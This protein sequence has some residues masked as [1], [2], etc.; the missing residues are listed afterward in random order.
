ME[1][2]FPKEGIWNLDS[3]SWVINPGPDTYHQALGESAS[4][5]SLGV[6]VRQMEETTPHIFE[7]V[8]TLARGD[9]VETLGSPRPNGRAGGQPW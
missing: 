7:F 9:R 3:H 8:L 6:L 2:E 1:R 5:L 4:S